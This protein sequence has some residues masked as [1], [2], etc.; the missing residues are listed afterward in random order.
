ME[1]LNEVLQNVKQMVKQSLIIT[2]KAIDSE[3]YYDGARYS[4]KSEAYNDVIKLIEQKIKSNQ[5][6]KNKKEGK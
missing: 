5:L 3:N 4:A 6:D 2:I 1:L